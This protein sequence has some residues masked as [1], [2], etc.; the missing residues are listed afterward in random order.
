MNERFW[1]WIWEI[2]LPQAQ[3]PRRFPGKPS[4]L[5][6][7]QR[8]P[9]V[10]EGTALGHRQRNQGRSLLPEALLG[11]TYITYAWQNCD[12]IN[13]NKLPWLI[14]HSVCRDE[15]KDGAGLVFRSPPIPCTQLLPDFT[16]AQKPGQQLHTIS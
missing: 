6:A 3:T 5:C 7:A 11:S 13:P 1:K 12:A 2:Q 16:H 8:W 9:G 14:P 4:G 10:W 15:G